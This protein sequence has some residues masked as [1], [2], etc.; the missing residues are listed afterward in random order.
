MLSRIEKV[1]AA[2]AK[3]EANLAAGKWDGNDQKLQAVK[4]RLTQYASSI[5]LLEGATSRRAET[6][7]VGAPGV[8]ISCGAEE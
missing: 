6:P 1:V 2:K 7:N 8:T 4:E 5:A 3:L